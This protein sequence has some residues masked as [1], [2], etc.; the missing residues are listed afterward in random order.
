LKDSNHVK[1][2]RGEQIQLQVSDAATPHEAA[3]IYPA[4]YWTSM[5]HPPS[6]DQLPKE[7]T[8]QEQWLAALRGGC[9]QCHQIGMPSTRNWTRAEDWDAIVKRNS[10]MNQA[11]DR[12]GRELVTKTLA[13]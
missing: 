12:L 6:Q 5:I 7:Y 4:S 2:A 9:N 11:A 1:A 3:K 10:A 13:D 8:S